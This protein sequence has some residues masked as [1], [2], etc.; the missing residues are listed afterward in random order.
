MY[1]LRSLTL[2][3]KDS[4][5]ERNPHYKVDPEDTLDY[6][7]LQRQAN[8]IVDMN[9]ERYN[10]IDRAIQTWK[11]SLEKY[12]KVDSNV[13][14]LANDEAYKGLVEYGEGAIAHLMLDWKTNTEEQASR[15][16]ETVIKRILSGETTGVTESGAQGLAK[17]SD[18]YEN[19]NYE[20]MP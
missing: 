3:N 5:I 14:D 8:L 15:S 16:R 17:W 6:N 19:K 10:N 1:M 11:K 2:S 18:W 4:K 7:A 9:H 20:D 13:T 12:C